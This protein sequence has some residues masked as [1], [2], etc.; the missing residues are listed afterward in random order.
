MHHKYSLSF[1]MPS[2]QAHLTSADDGDGDDE[3]SH[4]FPALLPPS[5]FSQLAHLST[6]SH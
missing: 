4:V 2:H 1:L 5:G 3:Y 6:E